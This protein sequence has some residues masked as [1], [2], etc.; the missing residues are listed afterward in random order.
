MTELDV[1]IKAI[2]GKHRD[3]K[4]SQV[5]DMENL[6]RADKEA[7]RGKGNK[8]GV[9]KF[10]KDRT[11]NLLK[12]QTMLRERTYH[13]STPKIEMRY[14][15]CGKVRKLTKLPYDPDHIIHHA[16]MQVIGPTMN[17]SYY[18]N[19]YASIKGRGTEMA[20]RRV[21]RW[22]DQHK[23]SDIV[24]AK[25][26]FTKFYQNI[27]QEKIYSALCEMYHDDG[28]RWLLK[29]VVTAISEGLGIGLYPIQPI[30][31]FYLNRLDR[32]IGLRFGKAVFLVRYCDDIVLL[33]FDTKTIWDAV[34]MIRD[35]A[36]DILRQPL[37]TNV[38]VEHL[39]N[40]VPLDFVGYQFFKDY[41]LIRKKMKLRMK[42]KLRNFDKKES[43]GKD[44]TAKR[45]MTLCS[46][47]GWLMHSN[48]ITLFR[49][50][51]GMNKF[52]DLNISSQA[53][54]K[55]GEI[56]Y[57]VPIVS[58]GF[59]V[60]RKIIVKDFQTN[61]KTRNGDGRYV[62]LIEEGGSECKFLTNNPRMKD[63]LNQC[64]ELKAFPFE[65][66]FKRRALNGNKVDYYFE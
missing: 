24:F 61:V 29:E 2:R 5:Y 12:I 15:P 14:C 54:G 56:Y 13:T 37:H 31:N 23:N 45:R 30:A 33:G 21:R 1:D 39:T 22:I 8:Y 44:M 4:L 10:D 55:N 60:G 52:S 19:S 28:I 6:I 35:Y 7:R 65:A 63:V 66:T 40:D 16:L 50:V 59:L 62:V 58:C 47:K 42:R 32:M 36:K 34:S 41:T 11:G 57:E 9:R 27:K 18:A 51:T 53:K 43:E 26:D 25:L 38:N 48:G 3:V 64:R 20:R 49:K 46:Y 17:A